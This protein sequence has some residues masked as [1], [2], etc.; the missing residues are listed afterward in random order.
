MAHGEHLLCPDE[1]QPVCRART[2]KLSTTMRADSG[3]RHAESTPIGRRHSDAVSMLMRAAGGTSPSDSAALPSFRLRSPPRMGY[4]ST[5]VMGRSV[6]GPEALAE[7]IVI[8]SPAP[9]YVVATLLAASPCAWATSTHFASLVGALALM[10][11]GRVAQYARLDSG[12]RISAR[13][14]ARRQASRKPPRPESAERR[15]RPPSARDRRL[16]ARW[17]RPVPSR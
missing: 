2:L 12:R 17:T 7:R 5:G 16:V 1:Q 8:A 4:V 13:H 10:G 9:R 14:G 11:R 6:R 15:D 3:C